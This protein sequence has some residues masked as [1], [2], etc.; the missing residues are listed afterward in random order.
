MSRA[1]RGPPELPFTSSSPPTS[2]ANDASSPP[3]SP[4]FARAASH[5]SADPFSGSAK[6]LSLPARRA[7]GRA[8]TAPARRPAH[9]GL[10]ELTLM[11]GA[12]EADGA[13]VLG[14]FFESDEDAFPSSDD[15]LSSSLESAPRLPHTREFAR[16]ES[17]STDPLSGV[18]G[19]RAPEDRAQRPRPSGTSPKK[20][21]RSRT[22]AAPLP[23]WEQ[24][25][26]PA[27]RTRRAVPGDGVH[28][29]T[30][31]NRI[32]DEGREAPALLLGGCQ[33]ER[34]PPLIGDLHRYVAIAPRRA[35]S[36]SRTASTR[37]R[38]RHLLQCYLWDNRLT[39]LPSALF[40]LRNLGVL[41]LRKNALT[42]LPPVIGEL[43]ALRELNV[44]GNA[45]RYL[46]A[47]I[48]RLELDTFTYVPNPFLAVPA[49]ATLAHTP[50][51]TRARG[52]DDAP[53]VRALAPLAR[54]TLPTLA[55]VCVRRLLSEH[56]GTMLLEQY[57]TGCLR[58]LQYTLDVPR[59]A[60]GGMWY[61]G[62][63]FHRPSSPAG[64]D[65]PDA[66]D[67]PDALD[68]DQLLEE[69]EDAGE[70]VYFNRCPNARE[71]APATDGARD[72]PVAEA[73]MRDAPLFTHA[74]ETRLEW[75]S[76]VAGV[77]VAKQGTELLVAASDARAQM[78]H[79]GC[80]P[81]LWR[82]CSPG[83]L[84]FLEER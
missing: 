9:A 40:Q 67:A 47:E 55:E 74:C 78:Q 35:E 65:A 57:E 2:A 4:T 44:G 30:L 49:D 6:T 33:L 39:R 32:F 42:H 81:L 62:A 31:I 28:W 36:H 54:H 69:E 22:D 26:A 20:L 15:V 23:A 58:M 60:R 13:E 77:R 68:V 48:Q 73:A 18:G 66:P 45:L 71:S 61:D 24:R 53:V 50:S 70:N 21:T 76:H 51:R 46:P 34:I 52:A 82:G 7:L 75:V 11:P 3:S 8:A 25:E 72:W 43:H 84:A 1:Y 64:S 5:A 59:A 29:P 17:A 10:A 19:P 83:C 27:A 16:T 41:S 12:P 56:E 80:L 37:E 38:A 79:S 14:Q 63:H